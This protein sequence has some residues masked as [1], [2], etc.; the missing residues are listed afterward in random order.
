[1]DTLWIPKGIASGLYLTHHIGRSKQELID[2]IMEQCWKEGF[3]GTI[4]QRLRQLQW[5]LV[6]VEFSEKL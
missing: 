3:H 1:M 4:D 2:K 6:E 5:V